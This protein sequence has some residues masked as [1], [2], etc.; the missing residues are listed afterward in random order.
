MQSQQKYQDAV[1]V[2]YLGRTDL[3]HTVLQL[4]G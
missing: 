1:E 3:N 4:D 2:T